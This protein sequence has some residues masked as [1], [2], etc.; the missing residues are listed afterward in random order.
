MSLEII[1][2]R[3]ASLLIGG[4][5]YSMAVVLAIFLAGISLGAEIGKQKGPRRGVRVWGVTAVGR[6]QR[7]SLQ[8]Y[9]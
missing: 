2:T 1:W 8:W 9:T 7:S 6:F 5:V 4:S 3:L